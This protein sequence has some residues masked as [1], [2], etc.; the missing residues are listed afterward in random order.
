MEIKWIKLSTNIFDDEKIQLIEQLPDADGVIVLWFKLLALAGKQNNNGM[1]MLSDKIPYTIEMLS[2][3]FRRKQPLVQ[4][5]LET[6]KMFGMID[7][8]ENTYHITNWDKHQV[9]T[10]RNEYM[11]K[12]MANK[13]ANDKDD[14]DV[15]TNKVLTV[16]NVSREE[17]KNKNKKENKKEEEESNNNDNGLAETMHHDGRYDQLEKLII[18]N[19]LPSKGKSLSYIEGN[20]VID[21]LKA[22][23]YEYIVEKINQCSLQPET[24][25]SMAYLKGAI[26]KGWETYNNDLKAQKVPNTTNEVFEKQPKVDLDDVFEELKALKAKKG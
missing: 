7:I 22:Y 12:F 9:I 18:W 5:A 16:S 8:V 21:W 2:T 1:I 19:Y 17:Y 25:R 23:P 24:K 6:F 14:K 3:I 15:S 11:K 4:L 26:T 10:S 13:R 20:L